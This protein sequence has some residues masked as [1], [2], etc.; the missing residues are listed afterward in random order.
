[1]RIA[2]RRRATRTPPLTCTR[3]LADCAVA[4][5]TFRTAQL[6]RLADAGL[7]VDTQPEPGE[8]C[9]YVAG[10]AWPA[11]AAV[12]DLTDATTPTTLL[13]GN[14]DIL[15]WV[16]SDASAPDKG[17]G[18]ATDAD[19]L[20]VRY[21]W[22]LLTVNDELVGSLTGNTIEGTVS[23]AAN[24]EGHVT[25]GAGTRLL[26]GVYIE[27]NVAIGRD[28]EIGP[29]CYLRG[30]TS[31]G[32]GCRIGNAVEIKNSIIMSGAGIGHL[33]YCGDSVVGERANFGAGT[34]TANLRHD[35][36][37]MRS[38]VCG[39]PVR[40]GRRKFGTIVGD[41]AHLGIHT[42]I[43]PGRKIWPGCTTLP[44]QAVTMD[45]TE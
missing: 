31:I 39:K 1:M 4:N 3:P 34:I 38:L 13:D 12:R 26:P 32:D 5:I 18:N 33:S 37:I 41:D 16:G 11:P 28:C 40:T 29:N 15:A 6:Q 2:R 20:V 27:G 30:N 43:Y 9:L 23:D 10:N 8:T 7:D 45:I 19:A 25:V 22:D 17:A 44:G 42:S 24:I 36:K 21:P 35:G 14:G